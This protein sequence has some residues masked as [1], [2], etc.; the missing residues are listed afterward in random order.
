M[1]RV[2]AGVKADRRSSIS[3]AALFVKVT[4]RMVC[5]LAWPVASS[6]AM[7]VV[8]TRVLPLPAPARIS[9]EAC[10][11]VTAASCSGFRRSRRGE[12][13]GSKVAHSAR[14]EKPWGLALAISTFWGVDRR[15]QGPEPECAAARPI[16]SKA[17]APPASG[18]EAPRIILAA[19]GHPFHAA[20]L[21][22]QP[23]VQ[24]G[25][26]ARLRAV[27]TRGRALHPR[28]ARQDAGDCLRRRSGG[29]RG[30]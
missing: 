13:I 8:S 11:R 16:I 2:L 21:Q 20:T 6:H 17:D 3:R 29:R 4:A 26:A 25:D 7:R 1:P 27:D 5:G 10:G 28:A 23:R 22:H 18:F 12:D 19:S 15:L 9:A 30:L 24:F 14:E